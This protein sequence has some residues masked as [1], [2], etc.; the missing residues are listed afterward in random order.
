MELASLLVVLGMTVV[1]V[2]YIARPLAEDRSR[3]PDADERRLSALRAEQ[4]QDR[5]STRLNSSH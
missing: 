5:K 3:E 4:D 2:A 1:T